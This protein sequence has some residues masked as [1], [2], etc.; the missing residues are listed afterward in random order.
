MIQKARLAPF[1]EAKTP[2]PRIVVMTTADA[3]AAVEKST[4]EEA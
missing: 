3:S 2:K 1:D 4:G